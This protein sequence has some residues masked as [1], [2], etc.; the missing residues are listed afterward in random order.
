MQNSPKSVRGDEILGNGSD[1]ERRT[2]ISKYTWR[3][4]RLRG[5]LKEGVHWV[6]FSTRK[7][8]YNLPLVQ[9]ALFN[10]FDSPEHRVACEK[11]LA[12]MACNQPKRK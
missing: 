12:S 1:L 7:V 8:L 3:D 6:R 11:F 5:E 9:D 10:G 2:G 4:K